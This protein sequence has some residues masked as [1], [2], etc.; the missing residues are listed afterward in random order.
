M[1]LFLAAALLRAGGKDGT[2]KE[3]RRVCTIVVRE[4]GTE[5]MATA[6]TNKPPLYD[7]D[8][9]AMRRWQQGYSQ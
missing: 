6:T 5:T 2:E 4:Y 9:N 8:A 1:L 3:F 7:D